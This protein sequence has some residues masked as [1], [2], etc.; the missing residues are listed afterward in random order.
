MATVKNTFIDVQGPGL[1]ST[2]LPSPMASAPAQYASFSVKDS[3]LAAVQAPEAEAVIVGNIA[4]TGTIGQTTTTVRRAGRRK[5]DPLAY[6]SQSS[7][8]SIPESPSGGYTV[9]MSPSVGLALSQARDPMK[10]MSSGGSSIPATPAFAYSSATPQASPIAYMSSSLA[11]SVAAP[12]IISTSAGSTSWPAPR[13]APAVSQVSYEAPLQPRRVESASAQWPAPVAAPQMTYEASLPPKRETLSLTAMIQSPTV[14]SK[15]IML[16]SA[17]QQTQRQQMQMYQPYP[18]SQP[19]PAPA[20]APLQPAPPAAPAS[21]QVAATAPAQVTYSRGPT[22]GTSP[23]AQPA[24]SSAAQMLGLMATGPAAPPAAAPPAMSVGTLA[25]QYTAPQYSTQPSV[26]TQAPPAYAPQVPVQ[27]P[28]MAPPVSPPSLPASV[29][30]PPP[31]PAAPPSI[32]AMPSP[33]GARGPPPLGIAM[34]TPKAASGA[35]D[36]KVLMDLAVASGNKEAMDAVLRQAQQQGM[37]QE[38]YGE[39]LAAARR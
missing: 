33:A 13:T 22:L 37:P 26:Y 23:P 24:P 6:A 11:Q 5:P 39:L 35:G 27:Q 29:R 34:A 3:L 25:P 15:N 9:P 4:E 30:M 38:K 12:E 10:Y 32:L 17:Y 20:P 1:M 16:H 18:Q 21:Y 31:P 14:A 8:M 2:P 19:Q 28:M 36:M 7:M